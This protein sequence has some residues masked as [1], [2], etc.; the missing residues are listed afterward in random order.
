MISDYLTIA[1]AASL[2]KKREMSSVD[3]LESRLQRITKLDGKL[4]SFIRVLADDAL[5]SARS[6]DNEI[7][8]GYYRGPLHGIP[9][10]L[11]DVYDLAGVPTTAHS[12]ILQNNIPSF[13][14]HS[15][16]R[17]KEAGAVI[18]GKL[19]THEFAFG[20]PSFDLPW[21]PARNPWDT[22]RFTGGS[23]SGAAASV[24]AGL[25]LGSAASDTGGSIRTPAA[26]CGLAG[27]KPTY[28]LIS[29]SGILPLAWSLESAGPIAWTA[30]DCAILLQAMAGFDPKD[31][32]SVN[33][34]IPDYTQSLTNDVR[35]LRIGLLRHFYTSDNPV[36]PV[37]HNAIETAAKK[38]EEMGCIVQEIQLSPL[39]EWTACGVI[40]MM[41][42]GYAIHEANLQKRFTDYGEV[43][44]DRMALAGLFTSADYIQAMRCRRELVL[45]F[46]QIMNDFDVILTATTANEAAKIEEIGKFSIL[47]RPLSTI[48]FNVTGSPAM[49]V[50]CG[51]SEAGL[52]LSMQI[53]G[54]RFADH[55][56]LRAADAYE[57]A[58]PWRERR[59]AL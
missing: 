23:S 6:L 36:N 52:P 37:A 16:K 41:A 27:L 4:N 56:V 28:G 25:V 39:S 50:C 26:Y 45:E 35:G 19:A 44:R 29:R 42:E 20:G 15:V 11:K 54:K 5:A 51:Y 22:T 40:I 24:A 31:P 49:S 48:T 57:R 12:K 32:T 38:F 46:D 10:G 1:K 17:L 2:I 9:I 30:E 55:T 3:L 58:T 53:V 59:P 13:D 18:I 34:P 43:F 8:A 21:P 33:H 7:S 47:E 14:A